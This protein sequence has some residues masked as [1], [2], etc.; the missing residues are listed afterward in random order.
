MD[1]GD[2]L[3]VLILANAVLC[4]RL[5]IGVLQGAH[6]WLG[7]L[8]GGEMACAQAASSSTCSTWGGPRHR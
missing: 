7:C 5:N 1:T 8:R 2:P 3:M 4:E 6:M